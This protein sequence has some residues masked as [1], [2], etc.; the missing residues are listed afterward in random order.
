MDDEVCW[1]G[2]NNGSWD[3]YKQRQ[4]PSF[5]GWNSISEQ[6]LLD[7]DPDNDLTPSGAKKLFTWEHRKDGQIQLPDINFDAGFGGPVPFISSQFGN[8]RFFVSARQE[9]DMYLYEVSSP[10]LYR[11]SYLLKLTSDISKKS[12]LTYTYYSG[13]MEGTTLSRGGGTSIVND[14]W[15]LASEVNSTGFTMPWRLFTNEYWSPTKF[16]IQP[17][18]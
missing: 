12:K 13:N 18:V 9:Q 16:K 11:Q 5:D 4:Y 7:D 6:T 3:E 8:L 15:D 1:T 10:G 17:M 2:T 14:V